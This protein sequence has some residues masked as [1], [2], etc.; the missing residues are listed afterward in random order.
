MQKKNNEFESSAENFRR[1]TRAVRRRFF[2]RAAL[3]SA[4]LSFLLAA[5]TG[6]AFARVCALGELATSRPG[7]FASTVLG[8]GCV[9]TLLSIFLT[10]FE[11]N[12]P[13]KAIDAR[14]SF[15]DRC[16]TASDVLRQTEKR[17]PTPIERLPLE[18]CFECVENVRANDVVS[19]KPQRAKVKTIA[20]LVSLIDLTTTVWEPFASRAEGGVPN[21]TVAAVLQELRGVVLP[22]V[23]ELSDA[24][25]NDKE[26]KKLSDNLAR[27]TVEI[28]TASDDPM[29]A[30]A[31]VARMEEAMK[32]TIDFYDVEG[33]ERV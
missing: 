2:Y 26:L 30:T 4:L 28:E 9:A 19:I 22:A 16:L 8:I 33:A 32:K 24:N 7:T 21:E 17:E 1:L 18:D 10:D 15:D 31:V 3:E 20:L 13:E 5:L 14:Y 27:W 29:K 12:A 11:R 23:Q 25:P 6:I